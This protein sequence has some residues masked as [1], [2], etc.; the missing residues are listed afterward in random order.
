MTTHPRSNFWANGALCGPLICLR[1]LWM[2]RRS[3]PN[4]SNMF[5]LGS[6]GGISFA[7]IFRCLWWKA[8]SGVG[9]SDLLSGISSHSTKV[10]S[11]R[12]TFSSIDSTVYPRALLPAVSVMPAHVFSVYGDE[13]LLSLK[14]LKNS[15]LTRERLLWSSRIAYIFLATSRLPL[16]YTFTRHIFEQAR[17]LIPSPHTSVHLDETSSCVS[18]SSS[19]PWSVSA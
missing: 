13:A 15:D 16:G 10:G 7:M 2:R 12:L 4:S 11:F 8:T 18:L 1:T 19:P 14:M 5:A 6:R 9:I 17:E 3:L